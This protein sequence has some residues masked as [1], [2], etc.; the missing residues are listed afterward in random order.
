M[1]AGVDQAFRYLAERV[2]RNLC[3]RRGG[4]AGVEPEA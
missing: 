1:S 2:R 4:T 3:V